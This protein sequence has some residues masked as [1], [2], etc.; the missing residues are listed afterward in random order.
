MQYYNGTE[1]GIDM[2]QKNKSAEHTALTDGTSLASI[3]WISDYSL[4]DGRSLASMF[5]IND[6]SLQMGQI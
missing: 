6:H 5:F 4:T 3:F 2:A 1:M